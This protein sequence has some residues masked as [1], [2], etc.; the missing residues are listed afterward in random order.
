MPFAKLSRYLNSSYMDPARIHEKQEFQVYMTNPRQTFRFSM[1]EQVIGK[2]F[3]CF[4]IIASILFIGLHF[5]LSSVERTHTVLSV[6][7]R[8]CLVLLIVASALG[9]LSKS[10]LLSR[11]HP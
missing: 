1:K 11:P 2:Y 4:V 10:A 5:G 3:N 6:V 7:T 9:I 8:V